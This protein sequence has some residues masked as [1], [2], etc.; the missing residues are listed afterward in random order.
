MSGSAIASSS[1]SRRAVSK[2]V[3]AATV[4]TAAMLVGIAPPLASLRAET[5]E[6]WR[7]ITPDASLRGWHSTGG[8]ARYTVVGGELIGRAAPG[9]ANSWLVSDT[10]YGDYIMEFDA[11]TDPLLNSGVMVRVL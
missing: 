8:N 4:W 6:P 2:A 7:N 11:K 10:T 9:K 3:L 5:A 1:K